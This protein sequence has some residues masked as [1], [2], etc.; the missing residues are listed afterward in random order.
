MSNKR[1]VT[2]EQIAEIIRLYTAEKY[3]QGSV[4]RLMGVSQGVVAYHLR[5]NGIAIRK[6]HPPKANLPEERIADIVQMYKDGRLF[7]EIREKHGIGNNNTLKGILKKAGVPLTRER[8]APKP[9][10]GGYGEQ[11]CWR[12]A[13]ATGKCSWSRNLTPVPGWTATVVKRETYWQA[14]DDNFYITACPLYE[15]G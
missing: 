12:C 8:P 7:A 1:K 2:D 15:K 13:K 14:D 5:K 3:S 9:H 6:Q 11:L 4:A 10:F